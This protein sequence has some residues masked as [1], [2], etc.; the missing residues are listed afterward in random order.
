MNLQDKISKILKQDDGIRK[1]AEILRQSD[2]EAI[3]AN[4]ILESIE[5]LLDGKQASDFML[6]FPIV[7]QIDDIMH[8]FKEK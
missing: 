4:A 8:R 1:V 6:S 7:R 3:Q 2:N 5:E